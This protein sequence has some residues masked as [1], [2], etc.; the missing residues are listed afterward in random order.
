MKTRSR[1][2]AE[3]VNFLT[4]DEFLPRFGL[5]PSATVRADAAP[6]SVGSTGHD[7]VAARTRAAREKPGQNRP[8]I[9][10]LY[11]T[12]ANNPIPSST[13]SSRCSPPR[14]EGELPVLIFS[15]SSRQPHGPSVAEFVEL[16]GFGASPGPLPEHRRWPPLTRVRGW[17]QG[18]L[19]DSFGMRITVKL[20]ECQRPS[21]NSPTPRR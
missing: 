11:A 6:I 13:A 16:D 18:S 21:T 14:P 12:S 10:P 9:L 19:W 17:Q 2:R 1:S 3:C 15:P 8:L 4:V 20:D 5:I 7:P